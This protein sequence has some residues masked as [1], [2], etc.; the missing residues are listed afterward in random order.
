MEKRKEEKIRF[1]AVFVH[2]LRFNTERA[3]A[4]FLK[5]H[6]SMTTEEPTLH[7]LF[8]RPMQEFQ[9][10]ITLSTFHTRIAVYVFVWTVPKR[11]LTSLNQSRQ[12]VTSFVLSQDALANQHFSLRAPAHLRPQQPSIYP[13]LPGKQ[14]RTLLSSVL[15]LC[16]VEGPAQQGCWI[17][18][19]D[20]RDLLPGPNLLESYS[21][22]ILPC[23][24]APS[25]LLLN[26]HP[27]PQV[28][29]LD[30]SIYLSWICCSLYFSPGGSSATG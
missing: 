16:K 12:P 19:T 1:C 8:I 23:L 10:F 25:L 5:H 28:P 30:P 29:S 9:H 3:T 4:T 27:L 21:S 20:T 18:S 13:Y 7:L 26:S 2:S 6:P 11:W 17:L 22:G 14:R 15:Y 24:S